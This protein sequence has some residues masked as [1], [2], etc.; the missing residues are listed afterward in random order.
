VGL[1]RMG[2]LA[3]GVAVATGLVLVVGA[4]GSSAPAAGTRRVQARVIRLPTELPVSLTYEQTLP[5]Y[6]YDR[7]VPFGVTET[8]VY[9]RGRAT[10][11]DFTYTGA[12]GV[13]L[14]AYLIVPSGPGP[15]AGVVW[16]G[17]MGD[18][19]HLRDEFVDEALAMADRGVA[20]LLVAGYFP[21]YVTPSDEDSDRAGMIGQVRELRRAVD[22]LLAR[23]DVDPARIAFVGHSMGAMHGANLT[24]VDRRIKA[25]VLMAPHSTMADW[26]FQ[27]YGLDPS[28]E[29]AYRA[30][31]KPFDPIAF[32]PHAAPAA[33]FFQFGADDPY[34]PRDV[35]ESLF[36]AASEPKRV[37]YYSGGHD[38]DSR[39]MAE[40]DAWLIEQLQSNN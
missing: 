6:E 27:G 37:G 25:A 8:A 39:A 10:F 13:V 38:L 18:Y 33:L 36:D 1:R 5:L 26:I 3:R 19:S 16:L 9:P 21:W 7:S 15:F 12:N 29:A 34:V 20:S 31:M 23:A 28:T 4:C 24:A 22:L 17:W 30:A 32:V 2:R 11:H 40:R 14:P 35:A